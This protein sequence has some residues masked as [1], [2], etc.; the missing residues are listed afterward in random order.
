MWEMRALTQ[1]P[2][3]LAMLVRHHHMEEGAAQVERQG[4]GRGEGSGALLQ[5]RHDTS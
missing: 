1:S 3:L 4:R 2:Q 5:A